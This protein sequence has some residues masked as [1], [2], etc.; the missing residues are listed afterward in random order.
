MARVKKM[1][2][3]T[4]ITEREMMAIGRSNSPPP[5][6]FINPGTAPMVPNIHTS[7]SPTAACIMCLRKDSF[8]PNHPKSKNRMPKN[9]G[10]SAVRLS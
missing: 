10:I 2:Q 8:L 9:D 3:S 7:A 4:N 1:T 5:I 6:I